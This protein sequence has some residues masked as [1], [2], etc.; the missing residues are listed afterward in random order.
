MFAKFVLVDTK[1][2][3]IVGFVQTSG[4]YSNPLPQFLICDGRYDMQNRLGTM[5]NS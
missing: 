4:F 3:E 5:S 1:F 2:F